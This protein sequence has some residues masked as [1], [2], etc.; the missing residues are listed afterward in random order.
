VFRAL[1]T[2]IGYAALGAVYAAVGVVALR[3][4]VVGSRDRASGFAG[5]LRFLLEQPHGP[6]VLGALAAGLA[7]FVAARLVDAADRRRSRTG[8]VVA[9]AD[10]LAHAGLAW[11]AVALALGLRRGRGATRPFLAWLLTQT[12][13][14]AALEVAAILVFTVGLVQLWQGLRG[15]AR[16]QLKSRELGAAA[17]YVIRVGRFGVTVRGIVTL[18]I[19]WF[20]HRTAQDAD[21]HKF[22]EIGGAL[23]VL[24]TMRFGGLL[25]AIAGAGLCAYGVYLVLLGFYRRPR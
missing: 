12:W 15:Y 23:E 24:H 8:R 14:K 5:A 6:I 25:L 21:V 18:V 20:L 19:G 1:L 22:H 13:G 10:A 7:A 17:P 11:L 4:A 2:R 9:L 16:R 3:V